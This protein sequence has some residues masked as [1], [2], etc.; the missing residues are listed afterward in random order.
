MRIIVTGPTGS[1]GSEII[2]RALSEGIEVAAIINPK[3]NRAINIDKRAEKIECDISNY[4]KVE[5]IGKCD[6]FYHLAWR[7][8]TGILRDDATIQ[9]SN[10][11][12]AL[13][14]VELAGRCESKC[15]VGVGSQAEYGLQDKPLSPQTPIQPLTAYGI[16]KYAAGRLTRIKCRQL[17][18]RHEWARV[19]SVYGKNDPE[20]SLIKYLMTS[21]KN[22]TIPELTKCEQKW[23]YIY[24]KDCAKAIMLIGEKGLDGKTYCIGSG[25]CRP[26]IEYVETVRDIVNKSAKVG[27]GLKNYSPNQP[28]MLCA[29][30]TE[31]QTDTGFSPEYDF[32]RGITEMASYFEHIN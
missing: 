20:N 28:M 24:A 23:D 16:C 6:I 11:K 19:L 12:Y 17:G 15:F 9:S 8:T 10:I 25:E 31:L 30:I 5:D 4:G 1:I 27:F 13:E 14:A 29:D 26:L 3:S 32:R 21:F 18:I 7:G 22:G 2:D